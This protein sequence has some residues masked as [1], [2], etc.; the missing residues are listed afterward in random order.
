MNRHALKLHFGTPDNVRSGSMGTAAC[1][2]APGVSAGKSHESHSFTGIEFRCKPFMR[3][4][5]Q[6]DFHAGG[7]ENLRYERFSSEYPP[8]RLHF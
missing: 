1:V 3:L 4:D 6:S 7:G 2:Q 5:D 8:Y